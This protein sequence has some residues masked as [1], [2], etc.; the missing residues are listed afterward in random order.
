MWRDLGELA[1]EDDKLPAVDCHEAEDMLARA[2]QCYLTSW[3][4]NCND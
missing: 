1:E 2:L 4:Q 3:P